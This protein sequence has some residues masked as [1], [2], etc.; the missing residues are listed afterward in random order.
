[1]S[2][3]VNVVQDISTLDVNTLESIYPI[4]TYRNRYA[5]V[6]LNRWTPQHPTNAYPSLINAANYGGA[7][8]VNSLDVVNAS[9]V[10]LQNVTLSYMFS[11]PRAQSLKT[12]SVYLAGDNLLTFTKFKG[13]DPDANDSYV[14]NSA[15]LEKANYN[16]FPLSR[17]F[18]FGV[19]VGF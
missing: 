3:L 18:R 12:L 13:Y 4:N 14:G 16:S 5:S 7:L 15:T 17:S 6:W 9:Y 19:T 2:A 10:R 1:L 11:F 8:S